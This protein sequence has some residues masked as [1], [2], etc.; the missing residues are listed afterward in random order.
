M[1]GRLDP[2]EPRTLDDALG[3]GEGQ[4]VHGALVSRVDRRERQEFSPRQTY[5]YI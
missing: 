2:D 3:A 5:I 1:A 4:V